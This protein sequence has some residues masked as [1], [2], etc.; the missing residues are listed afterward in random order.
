MVEVS[1]PVGGQVSIRCSGHWATGNGSENHHVYFCRGV[2][3]AESTVIQTEEERPT[4]SHRGRYSMEAPG[5]EAAFSVTIE[6]LRRADAGR[7]HCGVGKVF[8]RSYQEVH[9]TVLN[10]KFFF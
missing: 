8:I 5:G 7:Y 9:L 1:G 10:G 4:V 3:S 2:C 6:Q